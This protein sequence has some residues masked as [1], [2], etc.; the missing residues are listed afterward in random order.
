MKNPTAPETNPAMLLAA[1]ALAVLA[2]AVYLPAISGGFIWDDLPLVFDNALLRDKTGLWRIWTTISSMEAED[3]YRPLQ[4][5]LLWLQ[6]QCWG[7]WTAGYHAVNMLLHGAVAVQIWRLMRRLGLPGA[8]IGAALF[9]VHPVHAESVAWIFGVKDLVSTLL[10]LAAVEMYLNHEER[11]GWKWLALA[12]AAVFAAMLAKSTS[13]MLPFAIAILAWYRRGRITRREILSISLLAAITLAVALADTYVVKINNANRTMIVPP[14][15]DRLVQSGM[16]LMFYLGKLA[17]PAGLS[18]IYPQFAYRLGDPLHWLP[19]AATVLVTA[20][21]WLARG[22]IGRGPLACWLDYALMLAPMLGLVYFGFLTKSPVADRFQY[23]ASIGPIVG[24]AALAGGWIANADGKSRLIRAAPAIAVLVA[25]SLLTWRQA[26]FY[27]DQFTFFRRALE[28]APESPAAYYCLGVRAWGHNEFHAA[29]KLFAEAHRLDSK[30]NETIYALG[31]SMARQ[32][33]TA[34]AVK[35]YRD[36]IGEG[37]T[38][39]K[40]WGALAWLL[41]T[42]PRVRDPEQA[43]RVATECVARS[44]APDPKLWS[45]LAA[46]QAA[47]GQTREAAATARKALQLAKANNLIGVQQILEQLIPLY[48]EGKPYIAPPASNIGL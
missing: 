7:N 45:T 41:A 23:M 43:L 9:A 33:K 31:N 36:K 32:G 34:E 19:L 10:C 8:W 20:V 26:G 25:L 3:H 35:F 15:M 28:I 27:R 1:A 42:D 30:D 14:L 6:Y 18:P 5:T 2:F 21:L 11:G 47:N 39:A 38:N 46:A 44:K 22:S 24:I 37:C 29:E 48:D 13:T 12:A 4:Y 17:W 16:A 40:V